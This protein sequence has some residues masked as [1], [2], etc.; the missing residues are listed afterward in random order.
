MNDLVV[1][2]GGGDIATGTISKLHNCG[3]RVIIL[4][5]EFP[6]SIRRKVSFSE[7]IYDGEQYVEGIRCVYSNNNDRT[8]EI[9]EEGDIPIVIDEKCDILSV[10]SPLALVDAILAKKNTHMTI[11]MAPI[12]IGLG[13]GFTAGVDVHAVIETMRG[14]DLGRIIHEGNAIKNTGRPG[15]IGGYDIERVIHSPAIGNIVQLNDIGD[16]VQEGQI[17]A[18]VG[19]ANIY[20]SLT[21]ILR[22]IIRN[23][24][25]VTKGMKIADIDPR[26][27]QF[28]NCFTISDKARCIAGGVLEAILNFKGKLHPDKLF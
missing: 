1:V 13:P 3:F 20:A 5:K 12:T 22:G 8:F 25:Y 21:G 10:T 11:D 28:D 19:K 27:N 15:K 23:G 16:Y 14:H 9:L 6:S 24:Y 18:R 4:E 7:A 2:R 17:I 26:K